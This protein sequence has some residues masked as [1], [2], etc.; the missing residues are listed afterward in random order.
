MIVSL[1]RADSS[2][3]CALN[4]TSLNQKRFVD[5]FKRIAVFTNRGRKRVHSNRPAAVVFDHYFQKPAVGGIESVSVYLISL[6][7]GQ[8]SFFVELIFA[9]ILSVV[10]RHPNKS[11]GNARCA[12]CSRG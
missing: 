12:P 8:S 7:A 3:I 10:T 2:S 9:D 5:A 11:I 6:H 1:M 4:K